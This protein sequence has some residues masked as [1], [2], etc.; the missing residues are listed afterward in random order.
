VVGYIWRSKVPLK[1]K[2]FLWQIL[3]NKLQ[4]AVNLAKR[5]WKGSTSYYLCGCL[6]DI[7]HIFFECHLA[8]LVWAM[9]VEIF[10]LQSYP[11]SWE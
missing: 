10:H 8:K 5:G 2:F 9:I 3:N 7:D 11:T 6:E 4:A 1:I